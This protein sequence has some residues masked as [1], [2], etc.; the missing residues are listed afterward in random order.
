[1]IIKLHYI[2]REVEETELFTGKFIKD[3]RKD[4]DSFLRSKG[5]LPDDSWTEIVEEEIAGIDFGEN[6]GLLNMIS[7]RGRY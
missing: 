6:I 5:V 1:M 4:I 2:Y 7:I 3:I